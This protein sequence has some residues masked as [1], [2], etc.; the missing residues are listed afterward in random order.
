MKRFT[1]D[2]ILRYGSEDDAV[3]L[4]A[5][6]EWERQQAAYVRHLKE[7]GPKLPRSLRSLLKR[8]YL[9]DAKV[10]TIALGGRSTFALTLQLDGRGNGGLQL[11]YRL[12]APL[13]IHRHPEIVES[14]RPLEWLYD[15]VDL[16][17]TEPATF[18]HNILLT[19]GSELELRFRGF[20]VKRFPKMLSPCAQQPE[21]ATR[22]L[23][24]LAS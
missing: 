21:E 10:S 7:I 14:G 20:T 12:T 13:Q 15:E 8:Y 1:P 9:H 24:L 3:A 6:E 2:M 16:V 17:N 11:T 18:Q 4:A 23:E 19:D 22:E 5:S